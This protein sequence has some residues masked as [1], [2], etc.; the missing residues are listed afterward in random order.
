[1]EFRSAL[2]QSGAIASHSGVQ[3]KDFK[4]MSEQIEELRAEIADTKTAVLQL[5]AFVE[6]MSDK[7]REVA[8]NAPRLSAQQLANIKKLL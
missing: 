6:D 7:L 1:M 4:I 3:Y 5:L 2:G 8:P